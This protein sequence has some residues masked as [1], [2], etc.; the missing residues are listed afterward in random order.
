VEARRTR[1][2]AQKFPG[3]EANTDELLLAQLAGGLL[4]PV[5]RTLGTIAQV[6]FQNVADALRADADALRAGLPKGEDGLDLRRQAIW[7]STDEGQSALN[8]EKARLREAVQP[9]NVQRAGWEE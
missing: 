2:W 4:Q 7:E 5:R 6:S 3:E 9:R 1:R 8:A